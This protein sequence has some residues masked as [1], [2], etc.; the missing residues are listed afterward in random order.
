MPLNRFKPL[1]AWS[2]LSTWPTKAKST[3][4]DLKPANPSLNVSNKPTAFTIFTANIIS[5]LLFTLVEC[6]PL[7]ITSHHWR[8]GLR[9]FSNVTKQDWSHWPAISTCQWET[10]S[11]SQFASS[12]PLE[13][14]MTNARRQLCK[15]ALWASV[16]PAILIWV[17]VLRDVEGA[18]LMTK[19]LR[20]LDPDHRQQF[21][22]L[23]VTN[24]VF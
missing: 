18:S 20:R 9:Y 16:K 22:Y 17:L 11:Q 5:S 13:W 19:S 6:R 15:I 23:R 4:G 12:T 21:S 8:P 7:L 10:K 2:F 14:E 1:F 24:M 3:D